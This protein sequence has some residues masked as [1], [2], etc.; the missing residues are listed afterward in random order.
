[1]G[2]R[3]WFGITTF[4]LLVGGLG[5]SAQI[6]QGGVSNREIA[7]NVPAEFKRLYDGGIPSDQVQNVWAGFPYDSIE[8]ERT[9]CFGPCPI[10]SSHPVQGRSRRATRGQLAGTEG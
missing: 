3:S 4:T 10:L 8:L 6:G 7:A 5:L 9:A 1:M 2:R